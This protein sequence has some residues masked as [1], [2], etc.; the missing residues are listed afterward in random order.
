[1]QSGISASKELHDAFNTFVSASNQRALLAGISNEQLVPITTIALESSDFKEDL[2]K[3]QSHLSST[4]ATYIL[5]KVD[6]SA[7]NGYVAVTF[8][9]NAA[10][11]RQKMLFASTRLTLV[12]ELGIERFRDTLFATELDEL[13]AKG[14]AKHEQHEKLSA[15]LTEEEAGLAGVKDAEAQESQGTSTRRGHVSSKVNVPT[16]EG[17]LEALQSL[18]EEGCRGTLVSLKYVL[19]NETLQL[20][21]SVDSVQPE[22][23]AG[24][25][26]KD[27]PRDRK[28][29]V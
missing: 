14:W 3:L 25:I 26:A 16:G 1:M 12:R 8:V 13:T 9:P 15:P 17:V 24:L 11:V 6:P 2:Q 5:L 23:V 21:S 18:K 27:E 4:A 20:D 19:P 10:P 7:A 22:S 28:S 29:V